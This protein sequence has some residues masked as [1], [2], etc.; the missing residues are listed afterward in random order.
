M[1]S[2][3]GLLVGALTLDRRRRTCS[4]R[5][6]A[7]IGA[8]LVAASVSAAFRRVDTGRAHWRIAN[9]RHASSPGSCQRLGATCHCDWPT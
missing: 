6:A 4:A 5:S 3:A 9:R 7:W 2:M 8:T 1:D